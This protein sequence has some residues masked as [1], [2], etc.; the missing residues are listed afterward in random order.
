ME[1][2]M[3]IGFFGLLGIVFICL[4]LIGIIDWSWW[5]VTM[6]LWF[7]VAFFAAIFF[8]YLVVYTLARWLK[9]DNEK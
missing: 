3:N 2:K 6:P 7:G 4:K 9:V 1:I 8:F 5:W